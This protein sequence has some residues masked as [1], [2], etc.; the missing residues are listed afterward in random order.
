MNKVPLFAL[1]LLAIATP[2]LAQRSATGYEINKIS[3][4]MVRTPDFQFQ[5]DQKKVGRGE[6]WL[7]VEVEFTA[8]PE[9]TD[10]LTFKYYILFAGK[11][12]TGEVTHVNIPKGRGLYSVMYVSPRTLARMT[13]GKPI[14]AN[15]IENIAVQILSKGQL[16]AESNFK[17]ARG[18]WWQTMQQLPGLVLNKSETPFAPLYWDR[19]EAIKPAR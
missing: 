4:S 11:L 9:M 15:S 16:V 19:Y 18:P 2:V 8:V 10:E 1:A 13:G 14:S 17:E 6:Q 12:M 5:G 3:P 7:E